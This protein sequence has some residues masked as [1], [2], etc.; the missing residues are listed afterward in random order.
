M[1]DSARRAA[2]LWRGP[3]LRRGL[4]VACLIGIAA[5][6]AEA[7]A[8]AAALAPPRL[9]DQRRIN[10][11][12]RG[13]VAL[14]VGA[15]RGLG[16][17]FARQLTAKGVTVVATHRTPQPPP[18]LSILGCRTL[19]L[20]VDDEQSVRAAAADLALAGVKMDLIVY[21][22]GI[23]GPVS[24]LDGKARL[25]RP[26]APPVRPKDMLD[27]F[28]TNAVGL[29]LV[30]QNFL[31][32]CAAEHKGGS[33]PVLA[34]LSSK[35]ASIEDNSSGGAYAYRASKAAT[36]AVA[37]S[38]SVDLQSDGSA[39]VVLLH[40]GYVRTDM[41]NGK[42]LIDCDESVSGLLCAI[43]ATGRDTPFRWVDYKAELI[44]Y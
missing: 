6:A 3:R 25:G 21:N 31:P 4:L 41:T 12:G 18:S 16:L 10:P 38:L 42:G 44:P 23:Y 5:T 1:C 27:V 14:V 34:V 13:N 7:A 19:R 36:N 29:V 9:D 35:V 40:P 24:T 33:L 43:E 39:K 17:E 11:L 32:L 28:Q 30:A 8:A 37:K 26:E 2:R 22:S 20:D 15:S